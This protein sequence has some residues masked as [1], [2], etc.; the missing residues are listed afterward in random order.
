MIVV[1]ST[2][3]SQVIIKQLVVCRAG[4]WLSSRYAIVT[5]LA[6]NHVHFNVDNPTVDSTALSREASL[7]T[8]PAIDVTIYTSR[9]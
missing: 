1:L 7:N 4:M 3:A 5:S 2:C 8:I 9:H 6:A